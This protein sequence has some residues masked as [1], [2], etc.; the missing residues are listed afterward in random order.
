MRAPCGERARR[1]SRPWRRRRY[2][3]I[4]VSECYAE[5]SGPWRASISIGRSRGHFENP[6]ALV[7]PPRERRIDRQVAHFYPE[8]L[9]PSPP[10]LQLGPGRVLFR[11]LPAGPAVSLST[12]S[13]LGSKKGV[14]PGTEA[15]RILSWGRAFTVGSTRQTTD[16]PATA[17]S[18]RISD[19]SGSTTSTSAANERAGEAAPEPARRSSGRMPRVIDWPLYAFSAAAFSAGTL[20]RSPLASAQIPPLVCAIVTGMK[21]M[22]GEPMKPATN[23]LAGRL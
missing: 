22:A 20:M 9:A 6:S 21:F 3:G 12:A 14:R 19:P 2:G 5:R 13:V 4:D 23:L 11:M 16:W 7:S 8:G 15:S 10:L 1:P 18:S 17:T